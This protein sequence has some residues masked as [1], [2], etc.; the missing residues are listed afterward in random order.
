M[1]TVPTSPS[2]GSVRIYSTSSFLRA[3]SLVTEESSFNS[4][5]AFSTAVVLPIPDGPST[6]T[7]LPGVR[8][9]KIRWLYSF[10]CTNVKVGTPLVLKTSSSRGFKIRPLATKHHTVC[11]AVS[12]IPGA[13]VAVMP[14]LRQDAGSRVALARSWPRR[15]NW[16]DDDI[17]GGKRARCVDTAARNAVVLKRPPT[18][19]GETQ[20]SS[21]A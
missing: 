18:I 5:R 12:P 9:L 11:R 2:S 19:S 4:E 3:L 17:R 13:S 21:D 1:I 15:P 7:P 8:K 10:G 20:E 16:F 6:T 14:R